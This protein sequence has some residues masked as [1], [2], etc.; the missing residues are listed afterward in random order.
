MIIFRQS[1]YRCPMCDA[2]QSSCEDCTKGASASDSSPYAN[3]ND[4]VGECFGIQA[5]GKINIGSGED[6]V[7]C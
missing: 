7:C 4:D 3:C 1:V 2:P 6:V 5:K